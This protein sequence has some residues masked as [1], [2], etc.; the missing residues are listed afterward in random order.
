[1]KENKGP[2]WGLFGQYAQKQCLPAMH[3]RM[4]ARLKHVVEQGN[5]EDLSGFASLET[6]WRSLLPDPRAYTDKGGRSLRG[7]ANKIWIHV[8]ICGTECGLSYISSA[9][10][11]HSLWRTA[12][13]LKHICPEKHTQA[14]AMDHSCLPC[15]TGTE[16]LPRELFSCLQNLRDLRDLS[17]DPCLRNCTPWYSFGRSTLSQSQTRDFQPQWPGW[18]EWQLKVDHPWFATICL[19]II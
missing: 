5:H 16:G 2:A 6:A 3:C 15:A 9:L 19:S 17:P 14:R 18:E 10:Y 1:M 13:S 4:W 7:M 12:L 8:I 11:E